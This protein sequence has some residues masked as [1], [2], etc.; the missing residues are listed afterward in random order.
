MDGLIHIT[1]GS[2]IKKLPLIQ[3]KINP[4][5]E[6][7]MTPEVSVFF[8]FFKNIFFMLYGSYIFFF[9]T[10]TSFDICLVSSLSISSIVGFF[11][12]YT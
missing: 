1:L 7:E 5:F 9:Q 4:N 10:V 2:G 8:D 6:F 11:G 12:V 3:L